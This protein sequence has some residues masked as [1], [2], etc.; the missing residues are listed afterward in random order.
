MGSLIFIFWVLTL[1]VCLVMLSVNLARK[2]RQ[3]A[4]RSGIT[5]AAIMLGYLFVLIMVTLLSPQRIVDPGETW[6]F[7]HWGVA[8]ESIE[9]VAESENDANV[10]RVAIMLVVSNNSKQLP[11][12]AAVAKVFVTDSSSR[13]FDMSIAGQE[14]YEALHGQQKPLD[15]KLPPDSSFKTTRNPRIHHLI[16]SGE[17]AESVR[18]R[19]PHPSRVKQWYVEDCENG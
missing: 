17:A 2:R 14:A 15:T 3:A 11:Q 18:T 7:D 1:F 16:R 19:S 13:K 6:R 9:V 4:V 10:R 8:V 12:R 5:L